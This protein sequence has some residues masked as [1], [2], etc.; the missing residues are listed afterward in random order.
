MDE[1]T[2]AKE[3]LD[4]SHYPGK[5]RAAIRLAISNERTDENRLLPFWERVRILFLELGGEYLPGA[6]PNV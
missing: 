1:E 3:G 5:W 2:V 4:V 6:K